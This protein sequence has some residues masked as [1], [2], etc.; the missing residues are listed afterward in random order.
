MRGARQAVRFCQDQNDAAKLCHYGDEEASFGNAD[1][2]DEED[3]SII[4]MDV[5]VE[6]SRRWYHT[7]V[8]TTAE[9]HV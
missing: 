8:T 7:R 3:E 4:M 1:M 6:R 5:S 9:A 2:G